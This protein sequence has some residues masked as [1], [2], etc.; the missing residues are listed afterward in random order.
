MEEKKKSQVWLVSLEQSGLEQ[1][2]NKKCSKELISEYGPDQEEPIMFPIGYVLKH[3]EDWNSA[4][5]DFGDG[6]I[7]PVE[8][9]SRA[10]YSGV[11]ISHL[12]G[13]L[14]TVVDA[15]F[16]DKQQREA[17]KSLIR[18]TIW[19]FNSSMERRVTEAYKSTD[20]QIVRNVEM[21]DFKI[22]V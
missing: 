13:E 1:K 5:E 7:K 10:I 6:L 18:N 19:R 20:S 11:D 2:Q 9:L 15:S 3:P 4:F 22:K 14:L 12:E 21:K 8:A 17:I 16:A